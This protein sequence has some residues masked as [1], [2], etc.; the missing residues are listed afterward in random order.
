MIFWDVFMMLLAARSLATLYERQTAP[1]GARGLVYGAIQN[2]SMGYPDALF[3]AF[4]ITLILTSRRLLLYSPMRL[5]GILIE[6][7]KY[8]GLLCSAGARWFALSV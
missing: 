5:N 1:M 2:C 6:N 4:T 7:T 8:S 3:C